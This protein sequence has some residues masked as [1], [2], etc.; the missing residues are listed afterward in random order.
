MIKQSLNQNWFLH[1]KNHNTPFPTTIPTSV[2]GIKF[3]AMGADYIPE[4]HLLG[5]IDSD[6]R[7]QLLMDPSWRILTVS[8]YGAAAIILT[9]NFLICAT[10]WD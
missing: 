7:R 4:E 1:S 2:Y 9:M 5:K 3:F 10:S 6:R 8:A